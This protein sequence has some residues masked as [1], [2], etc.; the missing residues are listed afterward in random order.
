MP[1]RM[2]RRHLA[3]RRLFRIAGAPVF[4][5]P[6]YLVMTADSVEPP[7]KEVLD[8]LRRIA[9]STQLGDNPDGDAPGTASSSA[10]KA[11]A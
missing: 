10:V 1:L 6:V 9:L 4:D 7:L 11:T 2:V 8:G 3:D 5:R